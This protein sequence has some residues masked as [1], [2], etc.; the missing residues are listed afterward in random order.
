MCRKNH[1]NTII[2]TIEDFFK[3]ILP[4]ILFERFE[5]VLL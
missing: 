4:L 3:K 1:N 5:R 2:K